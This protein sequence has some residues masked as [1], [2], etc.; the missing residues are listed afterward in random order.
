VSLTVVIGATRSGKSARAEAL[1]AATGLPVRYVATADGSDPSMRAR[2]AAHVARRPAAWTTVEAPA[3]LADAVGGASADCVLVDG[4]GPWLATRLHRGGGFGDP[5]RLPALGA[6]ALA[7]VDRAARALAGAGA[8][9]VVAEQAGAGVLPAEPAS[10]A[11]LDLLGEATQRFAARAAVVELVVAGRPLRLDGGGPHPGTDGAHAGAALRHHGDRDARP[12]D[13][14]HAVNVIDGGP[15]TWLRTAL[16]EALDAD[17]GRYPDATAAG[18]ALAARHGRDPTE[19]VPTNGAA[20]ALWLLGPALR[21]TLAACV[22]PGFTEAEAALRAHG[23]P[24]VRVQR[25]PERDFRLDPDRV[26]AAADLVIAGNPASPS[27]TL[28]PAT[29]LLALRRPGRTVVVDEAFMDLVPGEPGTLAGTPLPD[30]IVVRSLTKVLGVPGLRAG[31]ALAPA[32]LAARLRA[33]QPPWS[34][35]SMALAALVA[36]AE[37]PAH[38][39]AI[40][41]RAA[42]QREDLQARLRGID[43]VRVWPGA[44][45]FVLIAVADGDGLVAA[46]RAAR[47]AVRPA[48]SFPGLDARHVRLTARDPERNACLADAVATAVASG[49]RR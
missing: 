33:V 9:I 30:V 23:L 43:G 34:A 14:D 4:L 24:V 1:A 39:A 12:G 42:A 25:D 29:A 13:A 48:A 17:A 20:E 5:A 31:Y 26:P 47:I 38:L 28:D 44:A 7:E 41:E 18:R 45:N 8:A 27:G 2:I 49:A 6:D 46:L 15:P 21:P 32:P 16:H 36:A 10:R 22:H 40:A 19:V 11:W 3:R 37:H 35:N